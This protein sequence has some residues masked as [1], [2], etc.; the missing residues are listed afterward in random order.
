MSGQV[1]VRIA[2]DERSV[3]LV[4]QSST[5]VLTCDLDA[6]TARRISHWLIQGAEH[7]EQTGAV[8]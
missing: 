8:R 4:V 7:V 2:P 1:Q 6:A 3:Q 5:D